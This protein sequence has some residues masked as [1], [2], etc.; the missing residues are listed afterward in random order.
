MLTTCPECQTTF[1][2]AQTQLDARRGLLRCGRCGAVF[3][4]FDSLLPELRV[5]PAEPVARASGAD[6]PPLVV[7]PLPSTRPTPQG[8]PVSRPDRGDSGPPILSLD[9][10]EEAYAAI[11]GQDRAVADARQLPARPAGAEVPSRPVAPA[12]GESEAI[13][14]S[15]LPGRGTAGSAWRGLGL[16]LVGLLLALLLPLQLV[17]F[18]RAEIVAWQPELRPWFSQACR[19]LGCELPLARQVDALRVEASSL[20]IDAEQAAHARLRVTFSNRARVMQAWPHFLLKLTDTA[21]QPLAQRAFASADYLP[22]DRRGT[23]GMP[24][25][26]ELE[27]QLDLHLGTLVAAG[28]EVRPHYP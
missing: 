11:Q 28:Y 2:V 21:G 18:M 25:M 22:P 24:A 6:A 19:R 27:F 3:N 14:L 4:G 7:P 9:P 15:E 12:R 20:E 23:P 1:R 5:P 26:S 8:A 17:Y 10:P 16:G 13:L